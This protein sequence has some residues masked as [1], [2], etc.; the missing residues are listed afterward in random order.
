MQQGVPLGPLVPLF[1]FAK[2][3]LHADILAVPIEQWE[4]HYVGYEPPWEG[5]TMNKLLW[6]GECCSEPCS[7]LRDLTADLRKKILRDLRLDDRSRVQPAY[8]LAPFAARSPAH[9]VA[10]DGRDQEDHLVSAWSTPR[11]QHER[12]GDQRPLHGHEL[13][14][15]PAAVRSRD[16][17][18]AREKVRHQTDDRARRVQHGA[19]KGSLLQVTSSFFPVL[20]ATPFLYFRNSTSTCSMS[21]VTAGP[22][23]SIVSCR[24]DPSFSS[25]PPSPSGT[26]IASRNGSSKDPLLGVAF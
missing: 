19:F 18:A 15:R 20:T 3:R 11:G 25:P 8:A 13:F 14:G 7:P 26:K 23:V 1:A 2:T 9:N 6:R 4:A 17:R 22:D 5:K 16:V 21:T 10:R 12:R 24:P